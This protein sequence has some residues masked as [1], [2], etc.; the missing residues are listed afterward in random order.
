MQLVQVISRN[1]IKIKRINEHFVCD[2]S[3]ELLFN[4]NENVETFQ[5]W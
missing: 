4:K 3:T 1:Q 2:P 5:Y